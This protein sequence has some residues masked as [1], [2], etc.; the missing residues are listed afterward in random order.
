MLSSWHLIWESQRN[1]GG[2][3][4][5]KRNAVVRKF[6][7]TSLLQHTPCHITKS[8]EHLKFKW[9]DGSALPKLYVPLYNKKKSVEIH[10]AH[11]AISRYVA[12][13]SIRILHEQYYSNCIAIIHRNLSWFEQ[14]G[15]LFLFFKALSRTM[16]FNRKSN[17]SL[18]SS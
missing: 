12:T 9:R 7:E 1:Q 16:K 11:C 10:I 13:I 17:N 2:R 14:H 4:E 18:N 3:Y 15:T 5:T 8:T 6:P